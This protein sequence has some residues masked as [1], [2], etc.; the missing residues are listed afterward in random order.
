MSV[1]G[2]RRSG[3]VSTGPD[4]IISTTWGG[5]SW[6]ENCKEQWMVKEETWSL[7]NFIVNMSVFPRLVYSTKINMM[8]LVFTCS[9]SHTL[10]T[11]GNKYLDLNKNLI[12]W[13]L[14]KHFVF[15]PGHLE[16]T[17]RLNCNRKYALTIKL[18]ICLIKVLFLLT[19][20]RHSKQFS[21]SPKIQ[22]RLFKCILCSIVWLYLFYFA[23]FKNRL[24]RW[25]AKINQTIVGIWMYFWW[26]GIYYI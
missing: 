19:D 10:Y 21:P 2:H 25:L 18:A 17:I 15:S 23:Q 20:V 3:K 12:K 16:T 6:G 14:Y 1:A 24:G 9:Q 26:K 13:K 7:Q 11:V 22:P 8:G 4:S 5:F